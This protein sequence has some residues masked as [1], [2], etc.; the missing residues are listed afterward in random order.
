MRV[1]AHVSDLHFGRVD[2]STLP[3]LAQAIESAQPDAL[4]VSGDLTQRARSHEFAEARA[5]LDSIPCP[6]IVVPGNHDIPLYNVI[7]RGLRPLSRFKRHF[8]NETEPFYADEEMA[9]AGLNTARSFSL[10]GGRINSMQTANVCAR[11]SALGRNPMRIVVT[12]HPFDIPDKRDFKGLVGRARMAIAAFA[13]C[14]VDL[15]LSGHMHVGG[16]DESTV[17]YKTPG[18]SMLLVQ[19]G[20]ASS[21]RLRG[22]ANSCNI[23]RIERPYVTIERM[24]WND[25]R[26]D[27]TQ[28]KQDRFELKPGGWARAA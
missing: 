11:F 10:K 8:G 16:A 3:A 14:R 23:I 5:F 22:E 24:M 6:K 18:H 4:V 13:H 20:T 9:I 19:A 15:L 2:Q 7:A 17:R 21:S 12:H 1:V 28:A 26:R 25:E 27:F